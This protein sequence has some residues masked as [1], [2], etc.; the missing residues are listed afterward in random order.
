MMRL[1]VKLFILLLFGISGCR[2]TTT[3]DSQIETLSKTV[4]R[5]GVERRSQVISS[6]SNSQNDIYETKYILCDSYCADKPQKAAPTTTVATWGKPTEIGFIYTEQLYPQS[7]A[8][9]P[10]K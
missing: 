6:T 2:T 1:Q 8:F 4:Q 7:M 10:R 3:S 5:D 9:N